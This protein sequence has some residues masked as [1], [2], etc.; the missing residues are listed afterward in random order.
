[1]QYATENVNCHVGDQFFYTFFF[2]HTEK[3][4]INVLITK[5]PNRK[6]RKPTGKLHDFFVRDNTHR[7]IIVTL[8][9]LLKRTEKTLQAQVK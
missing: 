2:V 1:M 5:N 3:L 4:V 9:I 6:I 8:S 7:E